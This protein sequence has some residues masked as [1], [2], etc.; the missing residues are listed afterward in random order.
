MKGIS[1]DE[2][3]KFSSLF[4]VIFLLKLCYN[5]KHVILVLLLRVS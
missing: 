1:I 3:R 2:L 5:E 4:A